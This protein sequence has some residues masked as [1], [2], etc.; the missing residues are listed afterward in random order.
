LTP[1]GL[2]FPYTKRRLIM[3][4]QQL[5]NPPPNN[6]DRMTEFEGKKLLQELTRMREL[7]K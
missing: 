6:L 1:G 7:H 5:G 4:F 3:I 2:V